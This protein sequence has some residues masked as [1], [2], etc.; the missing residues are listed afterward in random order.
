[1][2][3]LAAGLLPACRRQRPLAPASLITAVRSNS[4]ATPQLA[5]SA[6]LD[7]AQLRSAPSA[8][9][10]MPCPSVCPHARPTTNFQVG[11]FYSHSHFQN[12]QMLLQYP[13]HLLLKPQRAT[14]HRR[15][16]AYGETLIPSAFQTPN[17]N[18]DNRFRTIISQETIEKVRFSTQLFICL[19]VNGE[20]SR[21]NASFLP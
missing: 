21:L 15:I 1:M 19:V 14:V 6:P 17:I 9:R 11:P 13:P 12:W 18:K 20:L 16:C 4:G 10:L 5:R 8:L 3:R 7:S 2:P